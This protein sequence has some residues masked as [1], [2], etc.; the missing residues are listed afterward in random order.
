VGPRAGLDVCEKSTD[1]SFVQKN[2]LSWTYVF[3]I[4]S[5]NLVSPFLVDSSIT[6]RKN[7]LQVSAC[8]KVTTEYPFC[9]IKH[10][11]LS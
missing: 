2:R 5:K 3:R 6:S 10:L 4:H 11:D 9:H 7:S 1:M 8:A